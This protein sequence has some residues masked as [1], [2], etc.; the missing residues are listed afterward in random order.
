MGVRTLI[1]VLL[2]LVTLSHAETFESELERRELGLLDI[3]PC[4]V[5][6]IIH[7][8]DCIG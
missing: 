7:N 3:P 8:V 5:S 2:L 6:C 1:A 4:G